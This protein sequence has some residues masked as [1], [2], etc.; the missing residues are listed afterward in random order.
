MSGTQQKEDVFQA[1]GYA[2]WA[3]EERII[4]LEET[5]ACFFK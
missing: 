4:P 1:L 3:M 2:A 5:A